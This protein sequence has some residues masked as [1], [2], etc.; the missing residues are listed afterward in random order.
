MFNFEF[1]GESQV[2]A[3]VVYGRYIGLFVAETEL[4][5]FLKRDSF[6]N[7]RVF[8]QDNEPGV[9]TLLL[10]LPNQANTENLQKFVDNLWSEELSAEEKAQFLK[11][12]YQFTTGSS[13]DYL[14]Y[15]ISPYLNILD[16][17]SEIIEAE[18][19][20]VKDAL[21]LYV[22]L[23]SHIN[24]LMQDEHLPKTT[25]FNQTVLDTKQII[26]ELTALI[27]HIKDILE[28]I[29]S[30]I[31]ALKA[32]KNNFLKR[33]LIKQMERLFHL[34]SMT[35]FPHFKTLLPSLHEEL[36]INLPFL[37][38]RFNVLY[39]LMDEQI[40]NQL[41]IDNLQFEEQVFPNPNT[42]NYIVIDLE[43]KTV[44]NNTPKH[45]KKSPNSKHI[46]PETSP[47]RKLDFSPGNEKQ[48]GKT[49]FSPQ[50]PKNFKISQPQNS[51]SNSP[52]I[53]LN[54][55]PEKSLTPPHTQKINLGTNPS[56][57][58][59]T[60]ETLRPRSKA[61][62]KLSPNKKAKKD[63]ELSACEMFA[64]F[65]SVIGWAVLIAYAI[66]HSPC[67]PGDE[68]DVLEDDSPCCSL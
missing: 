44:K 64:C 38:E 10:Q 12:F 62:E 58:F 47:I 63:W 6:K 30:C 19:H 26:T 42:N 46:E 1:H 50:K 7:C 36:S 56:T 34:A 39:N 60:P 5:N 66:Y 31:K 45:I 67:Y 22:D 68:A 9:S 27:F 17:D 55:I 59:S 65:V 33:D 61:V 29:N 57:L 49:G 4:E 52:K 37:G 28:P 40:S 13:L 43:T 32:D 14:S 2:K 53:I 15:L 18:S 51:A 8:E 16:I 24:S 35:P 20:Y 41:E 25:V 21:P 54:Q 11:A 48:Y 23:I 3:I